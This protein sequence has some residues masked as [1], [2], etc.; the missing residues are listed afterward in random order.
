MF[1]NCVQ[2]GRQ[3]KNPVLIKRFDK[4][5]DGAH[6]DCFFSFFFHSF[7]SFMPDKCVSMSDLSITQINKAN[8]TLKLGIQI[9]K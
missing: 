4:K 9:F 2:N 3:A 7:F 6:D 5:K 8:L 1:C